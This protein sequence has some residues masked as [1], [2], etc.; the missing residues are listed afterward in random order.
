MAGRLVSRTLAER[1]VYPESEISAFRYKSE[2]GLF[3]G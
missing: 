3:Q 1:E 2:L